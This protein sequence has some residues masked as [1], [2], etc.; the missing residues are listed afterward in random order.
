MLRTTGEYKADDRSY[1][2]HRFMKS[3]VNVLSN[4][5]YPKLYPIHNIFDGDSLAPGSVIQ[6]AD[7]TRVSVGNSLACTDE[8]IDE[9]GMY[10]LDSGE[11][12]YFY[13]KQDADQTLIQQIFAVE[14]FADLATVTSF[15]PVESE[16][17]E[18]VNNIVEQLRKFKNSTY[19]SVRIVPEKDPHE[20]Q[21]FNLLVED[22]RLGVSYSTF[23]C[24]LHRMIGNKGN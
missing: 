21:L 24:D 8:K 12:I 7:I 18:R 10:L 6:T 11:I 13:V 17:F 16:Y 2:L 9:N 19:Q 3:P 14:G 4:I 15:S 23:L 5:W 22:E 1:D 20:Q